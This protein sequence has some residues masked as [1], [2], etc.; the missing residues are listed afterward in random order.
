MGRTRSRCRHLRCWWNN[1]VL[2]STPQDTGKL[3]VNLAKLGNKLPKQRYSSDR[4]SQGDLTPVIASRCLFWNLFSF[5]G[6][7]AG[8]KRKPRT[9]PHGPAR[10]LSLK[11]KSIVIAPTIVPGRA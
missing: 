3:N 1:S 11:D 9:R 7:Q 6:L 5:L 2:L 8:A 4:R 10:R